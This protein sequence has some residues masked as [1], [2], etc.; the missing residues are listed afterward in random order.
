MKRK[1]AIRTAGFCALLLAG[2]IGCASQTS[3]TPAEILSDLEQALECSGGTWERQSVTTV[4][5][6][7]Y[8]DPAG[9]TIVYYC[10][11]TAYFTEDVPENTG[12]DTDTLGLVI[13]LAAAENKRDCTVGSQEAVQCEQN[14]RTFLCWTLS[15]AVSCVIEY[16][17][18]TAAE[19]D[20]FRMAESIQLPETAA[21]SG[22]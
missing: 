2:I 20:I 1:S 11:Q 18:E 5:H 3:Q 8:S 14:G 10:C 17:A 19:A 16:T 12:L 21:S 15:P 9:N 6:L 4:T 7:T 13:D 22:R